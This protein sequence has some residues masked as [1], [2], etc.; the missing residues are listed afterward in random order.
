MWNLVEPQLDLWNLGE[1]TTYAFKSGTSTFK[2]GTFM[3]NLVEPQL[4]TV[5]PRC[6][7]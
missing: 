5:E 2:G 7:T 4:L 6:G 1:H 3:W